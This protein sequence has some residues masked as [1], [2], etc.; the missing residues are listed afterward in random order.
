MADAKVLIVI[1]AEGSDGPVEDRYLLLPDS[2]LTKVF[3]RW[4]T[5]KGTVEFPRMTHAQCYY[6]D[7]I[8][9]VYFHDAKITYLLHMSITV[10]GS[11]CNYSTYAI[12]CARAMYTFAVSRHTRRRRGLCLRGLGGGALGKACI[13]ATLCSRGADPTAPSVPARA[14]GSNAGYIIAHGSR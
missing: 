14:M 3:D 5:D 2:P 13:L 6:D 12:V 10:Y 9:H 7:L 4:C 11:K 1:E 8:P